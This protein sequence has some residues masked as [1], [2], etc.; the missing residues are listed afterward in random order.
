MNYFKIFFFVISFASNG[1]MYSQ[2][3]DNSS[4]KINTVQKTLTIDSIPITHQT[5]LQITNIY[6]LSQSLELH[7]IS[8]SASSVSNELN[9][10]KWAIYKIKPTVNYFHQN[11]F[12]YQEPIFHPNNLSAY[13]LQL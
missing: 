4:L 6:K 2:Y 1:V 7:Y 12:R 3:T 5:K 9:T 10:N 11:E 13:G 8:H